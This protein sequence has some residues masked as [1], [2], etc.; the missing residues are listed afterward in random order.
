MKVFFESK[1][2]LF[3]KDDMRKDSFKT[4]QD[5]IVLWEIHRNMFLECVNHPEFVINFW[6]TPAMLRDC[7]WLCAYKSLPVVV[8]GP[9]G[10]EPGSVTCKGGALADVL[11]L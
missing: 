11:S 9:H 1:D 7:S 4:F 6:V 8:R 3:Y 10:I 5:E 2:F